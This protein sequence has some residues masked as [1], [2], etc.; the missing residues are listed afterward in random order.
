MHIYLLFLVLL[1]H[2]QKGEFLVG[3]VVSYAHSF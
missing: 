2:L 3:Q 1:E